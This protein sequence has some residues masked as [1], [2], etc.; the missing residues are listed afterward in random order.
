MAIARCEKHPPRGTKHS[1]RKYA[2]PT[3]YPETAAICGRVGCEDPARIWLT[4]E[5]GIE[6][7]RGVRIFN[8]RTHA[9]KLRASDEVF[10]VE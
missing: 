2:L 4:D 7:S 1:Y 8:I 3:G 10:S 5:D 6:H 9:A